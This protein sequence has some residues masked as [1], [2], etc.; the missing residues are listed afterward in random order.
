MDL[1]TKYQRYGWIAAFVIIL[2]AGALVFLVPSKE[3]ASAEQQSAE[4]T[5]EGV[6]V[7]T[8]AAS[9]TENS[10]FNF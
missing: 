3:E 10:Q 5:A 2:I 7:P 1:F 4:E 8:P 9:S 6:S